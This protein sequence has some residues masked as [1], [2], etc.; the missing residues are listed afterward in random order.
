MRIGLI[1]DTHI[2]RR[3][4]LWPQVFAAFDGVDAILHAGDVWSPHLIDELAELAPVRVARGNG[5]AM[6]EDERFEERCLSRC[7]GVT[8]GM[9]HEF[10]SPAW[11][12]EA[13]VLEQAR[14][15][16]GGE[17]PDVIVC[18]HTHIEAAHC[19]DGLLCVNPGSPTQP[20][21]KSTRLG[22]IGFLHIRDGH[23][24]AELCRLTDAGIERISW[25]A[26]NPATTPG[27][28]EN[29]R[30]AVRP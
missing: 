17:A 28:D 16:F 23:A 20:H 8:V 9:L 29:A 15:R 13:F 3:G 24:C 10:P 11:Q 27:A 1:A 18:G 6:V 26:A 12:P 22:T 25:L 19:L 2:A 4:R 21:N 7:G 30:P 14:R 5:D